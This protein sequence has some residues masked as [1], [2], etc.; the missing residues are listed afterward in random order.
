MALVSHLN[1]FISGLD[2]AVDAALF[3]GAEHILGESNKIVP[4]EY[5]D[6]ERSGHVSVSDGQA[7]V[8]YDS[9]YARRQHEEL[10]WKHD[11]G[12][13]AKYLEKAGR[14]NADKVEQLIARALEQE[15][16]G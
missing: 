12:R 1:D 13:E 6:L 8:Y 5:G 10:T 15:G 3:K 4:H 11:A 7:S 14:R 16:G 9:V 2:S